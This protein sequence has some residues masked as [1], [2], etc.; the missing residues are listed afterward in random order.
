MSQ[1]PVESDEQLFQAVNYLLSGPGGLGQSF[2]G[3]KS[4][5]PAYLTGN[6]RRPYTQSTTAN[7]YVPAVTLS[8]AEMLSDRVFKYTFA[9]TQPSAPFSIG[10]GLSISGFTDNIYNT[11][12]SSNPNRNRNLGQIGVVQCTTDYVIIRSIVVETIHAPE[13]ATGSAFFYSTE[14]DAIVDPVNDANFIATDC[15]VRVTVQGG[16][17][18]VFV[19]GQIAITLDYECT[20]ATEFAVVVEIDRYFGFTNNDPTNPDY[21]FNFD[22]TVAYKIYNFS[23]TAGT[24]TLPVIDQIFTTLID[25]P[26]PGYYRYFINIGLA[27]DQA[28][29]TDAQITTAEVDL[30]NISVQVVKQ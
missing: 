14:P 23:V 22:G 16:S 25:D 21:L 2:N 20:A 30:R 13:F 19:G 29:I 8:K 4:S 9:S 24:G 5:E 7:L 1:Y 12:P 28:N 3:F 17:E 26:A 10:Q 18:R 15:D 27:S 11:Y 6:F